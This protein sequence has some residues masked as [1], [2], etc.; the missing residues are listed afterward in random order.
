LRQEGELLLF[1]LIFNNVDACNVS[2]FLTALEGLKEGAGPSLL[3]H[4]ARACSLFTIFDPPAAADYYEQLY[5]EGDWGWR[6]ESLREELAEELGDASLPTDE[7]VA[8]R[9]GD[10]GVMTPEELAKRIPKPFQRYGDMSLEALG[11]LAHDQQ[12]PFLQA[13]LSDLAILQSLPSPELIYPADVP[14]HACDGEVVPAVVL[15]FGEIAVSLEAELADDQINFAFSN[16]E[17]V[18]FE[19]YLPIEA[20]TRPP[21]WGFSLDS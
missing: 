20:A 21:P 12:L 15:A 4:I 16:G 18:F 14:G 13:I 11:K 2:P 1:V 5:W 9:L 10:Q 8:K 19:G 6:L 3:W 17:A 7:F